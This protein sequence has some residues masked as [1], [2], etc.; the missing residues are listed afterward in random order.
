MRRYEGTFRQEAVKL[1]L[2]IG[3]SKAARELNIPNGTLD[4]WL[5]KAKEGTLTGG[6]TT[7]KRALSLAEENKRLT[8]ENRELRR[9][10]EILSKAA[11]FF[12]QS[13]KK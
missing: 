12:A 5:Q 4:T 2:E 6:A 10:N 11:A 3:A 9:T 13:R 8:Q 7:P 1:A